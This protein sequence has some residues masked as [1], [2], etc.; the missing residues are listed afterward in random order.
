[1]AQLARYLLVGA[2]SFANC[3]VDF[4]YIGGGVV[5]TVVLVLVILFLLGRI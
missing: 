4:M 2:F 3:E 1:M 5:G